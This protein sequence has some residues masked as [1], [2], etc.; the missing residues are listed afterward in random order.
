MKPADLVERIPWSLPRE[1]LK[2]MRVDRPIGTWLLLWPALWSLAAAQKAAHTVEW[3]LWL[4]VVIG[5]FVM[6][7]AGCV[8]NDLADRRFDPLVARTRERPLAAGRVSVTAAALL[9]LALLTLAFALVTMLSPLAIEL[10]FAGAFLA[11]TYPFTKRFIRFPQFYMGAAFG[12]GVVI[13]WAAVTDAL[14]METWLIFA[15]TLA[16]AAGYD[17]IYAMMDRE[18]DRQIGVHST[19]LL[20]GRY[21]IPAT[22]FL[23]EIA[24]F[25]LL[26]VGWRLH[27][28]WWYYGMLLLAQGQMIWQLITIREQRQEALFAAFLSNKWLGLLILLG[29]F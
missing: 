13:A 22:A 21:V 18:D 28:Q 14:A 8:A 16:W 20:F 23:Y 1:L 9:L 10:A 15:A 2:L 4:I 19:A 7:S 26:L 12:W 6:R 24:L 27:W 25:L 3:R 29:F 17:T 11:V 5:A